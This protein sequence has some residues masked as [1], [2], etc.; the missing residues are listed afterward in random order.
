MDDRLDGVLPGGRNW[1]RTSDPSLV[2]RNQDENHTRSRTS[3][4]CVNC[5]NSAR[6]S[7]RMSARV[8][9]VVPESGSRSASQDRNIGS[10]SPHPPH[11]ATGKPVTPT[12]HRTQLSGGTV[13]TRGDSA[14]RSL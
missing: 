5:E 11:D 12:P 3:Y 13:A 7:L 8:S 9:M 14:E 10:T 4:I 1:V 6:R 2:R